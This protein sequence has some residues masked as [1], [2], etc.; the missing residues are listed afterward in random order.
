MP[1][2]RSLSLWTPCTTFPMS[3]TGMPHG[4][5]LGPKW[6]AKWV[7]LGQPKWD[8]LRFVRG[9]HMGPKWV[10][11]YFFFF[12][13]FLF[14]LSRRSSAIMS[15]SSTDVLFGSLGHLLCMCDTS[16]SQLGPTYYFPTRTHFT[17]KWVPCLKLKVGLPTLVPCGEPKWDPLHFV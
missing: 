7:P 10:C 9:A 16:G 17:P 5:H 15:W 1:T 8:P 13:F 4:P 11:P 3:P 14:F 6:A 12:L 2:L